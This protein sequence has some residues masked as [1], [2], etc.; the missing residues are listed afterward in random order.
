MLCVSIDSGHG[1]SPKNEVVREIK[2]K[3]P[4]LTNA[5]LAQLDKHQTS[6]P[7]MVSMSTTIST[8]G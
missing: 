5:S 4:L 8:G 3:I 7:V 6:K 2:F 1:K